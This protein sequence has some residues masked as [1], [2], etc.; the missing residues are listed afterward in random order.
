MYIYIYTRSIATFRGHG[1]VD[2]SPTPAHLRH[3]SS[4]SGIM[5]GLPV[6]PAIIQPMD[7]DY[8][9]TWRGLPVV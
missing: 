3:S 6:Y 4:V 5:S 8:V 2:A 9:E 7:I 1:F